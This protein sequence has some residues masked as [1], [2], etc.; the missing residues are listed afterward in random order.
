MYFTLT[1]HKFTHIMC[2]CTY[3]TDL[4]AATHP[5]AAEQEAPDSRSQQNLEKLRRKCTVSKL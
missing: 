4:R 2:V 3:V 1:S 5:M